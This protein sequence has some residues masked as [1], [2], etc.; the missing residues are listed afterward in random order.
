MVER[1]ILLLVVLSLPSII[2]DRG[3]GGVGG[4]KYKIYPSRQTFDR[5]DITNVDTAALRW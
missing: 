5:S 1:R 2:R 3:S 4:I